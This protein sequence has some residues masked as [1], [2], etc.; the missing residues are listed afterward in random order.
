MNGVHEGTGNGVHA[1]VEMTDGTGADQGTNVDGAGA[2]SAA[3]G[4]GEGGSMDAAAAAAIM[5]DAGGRARSR[6]RPDHRVTFAVWGLLYIFGYG[7][8][9]LLVRGQHPV[10]GPAPAAFATVTLLAMMATLAGAEEARSETGVRGLSAI[11]RRAFMLST[12][13]GFAAMFALE[14][15]LFRAGASRPVLVVFEASA[16]IMVIGLLYL[17][18]ASSASDWPVAGLGL[19]LVI[20]AAASGYAGPGAVWGVDAIAVGPAFLL[21][22]AFEPWLHRS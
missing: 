5:A 4:R 18:R 21:V 3:A 17:A 20:V 2:Y 16:P 19:W 15:A 13:A 14:G 8:I 11:R 1:G 22:A 6:L 7:V 9:W 12:V 10:H